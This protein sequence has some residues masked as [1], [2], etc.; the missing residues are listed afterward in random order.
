ML[1]EL[2]QAEA[3]SR[4]V[5]SGVRPLVAEEDLPESLRLAERRTLLLGGLLAVALLALVALGLAVW[6]KPLARWSTESVTSASLARNLDPSPRASVTTALQPA[7][8]TLAPKANPASPLENSASIAAPTAT[9]DASE[10]TSKDTLLPA[11]SA[12]RSL[13]APPVANGVQGKKPTPKSVSTSPLE[14]RGNERYGRFD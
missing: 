1:S 8:P 13:H 12:A 14:R 5:E 9:I 2:Q 4:A 3:T 6:G 7:A 10:S 11:A